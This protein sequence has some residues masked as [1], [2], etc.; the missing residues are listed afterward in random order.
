MLTSDQEQ[1]LK[2]Y[3]LIYSMAKILKRLFF[4]ALRLSASA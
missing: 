1:T 2:F 4:V 3:Y